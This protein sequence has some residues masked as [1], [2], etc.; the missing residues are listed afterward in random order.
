MRGA[1]G[2]VV[3]QV[4]SSPTGVL[5]SARASM[6]ETWDSL[7][8]VFRNQR[9]RR[10]QLAPAGSLIGDW[11]YA[12]AVAVFAYGVGGAKAVGLYFTVRLA[13]LAVASPMLAIAAD[14]WP[15][16]MVMIVSDLVRFG[17]VA[18]AAGCLYLD[19]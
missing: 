8:A 11:A 12:T 19:M 2:Y 3:T 17:L 1:G 14:K 10:L 9:L 4:A 7:A 16:K 13:L 6:R 18:L 5:R 15:R